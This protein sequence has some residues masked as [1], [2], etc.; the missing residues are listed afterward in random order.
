MSQALFCTNCKSETAGSAIDTCHNCENE[1]CS[2]CKSRHLSNGIICP[3]C[4]S[5]NWQDR[6]SAAI[7]AGGDHRPFVNIVAME[8]PKTRQ[9]RKMKAK[10]WQLAILGL[11]LCFGASFLWDMN[12]FTIVGFIGFWAMVAGVFVAVKNTA[13]L[14]R[15][16]IKK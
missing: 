12:E 1:F 4:Q 10:H 14:I 11:L 8:L 15:L 7:A 9:V 16:F 5:D 6:A 13:V 2:G 3:H